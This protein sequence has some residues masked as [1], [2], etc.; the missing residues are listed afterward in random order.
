MEYDNQSLALSKRTVQM[1]VRRGRAHDCTPP[2]TGSSMSSIW[3]QH[4]LSTGSYGEFL[5]S[6]MKF[7]GE[8]RSVRGPRAHGQVGVSWSPLRL[9]RMLRRYLIGFRT[10]AR[11]ADK[12]AFL[13]RNTENY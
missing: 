5:L 7:V 8:W 10:T 6:F 11:M 1:I 12:T 4:S 2:G 9:A 3:Y 13:A